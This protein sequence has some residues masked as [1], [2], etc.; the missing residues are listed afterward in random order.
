MIAARYYKFMSKNAHISSGGLG[1]M[2]FA[3]PAAIGAKVGVGDKKEVIA[4]IGDGGFQMN[5][6]E[7][8]VLR[9]ENLN[10]K[11]IILNNSF[12]GMVRQWQQL[13]FESRYSHTEISSPD[14]YKTCRSL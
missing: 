2:G 13:F 3:L 8:A 9:Q 12:L 6:Q 11:I 14:F 10:L 7:L 5:L 1:T 4:V